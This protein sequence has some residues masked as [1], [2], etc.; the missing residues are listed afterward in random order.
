MSLP[1]KISHK[2]FLLIAVPIFFDLLFILILWYL[3]ARTDEIVNAQLSARQI[4][5]EVEGSISSTMQSSVSMTSYAVF[6]QAVYLHRFNQQL[7]TARSLLDKLGASVAQHPEIAP[8]Y[9]DFDKSL[10]ETLDLLSGVRESIETGERT[11]VL[12]IVKR[13]LR[14]GIDHCVDSA[15]KLVKLSNEATRQCMIEEESRR[16]IA[17]TVLFAGIGANLGLGV[18]F[19]ILFSRDITGRIAVIVDNAA[20]LVGGKTLQPQVGGADEIAHL[21]KVFHSM[22]KALEEAARKERAMIDKAVDVIC[23]LDVDYRV[24]KMNAAGEQL[25]HMPATEMVGKAIT[26]LI[27]PED[28]NT[29]KEALEKLKAKDNDTQMLELRYDAGGSEG[30]TLW[31]INWSSF[32]QAYFCVVHDITDA[33][34][35][36]SLKQDFVN[37]VSHDLRTPLNSMGAFLELLKLG[38]YGELSDK[39]HKTVQMMEGNMKRLLALVNNLLDLEKMESG[40]MQLNLEPAS[41]SAI[42]N[43]ALDL[44]RGFADSKKIILAFAPDGDIEL[45]ADAMRLGQVV[46]NLVSNAVKF[47]PANS[48]VMVRIETSAGNA[49]VSVSDRGC[50]IAPEDL[51]LVFEKFKQIKG[52]EQGGSGLGLA[53][54]KAIVEAHKGHIGVESTLGEGTTF[55]LTIPLVGGESAGS[56]TAT[57]EQAES[58]EP[59]TETKLVA[60]TKVV[61]ES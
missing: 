45:D 12:P 22:A 29:L 35:I 11:G 51:G 56:A 14:R 47:S 24:S 41:L 54:C 23:S 61:A 9:Q 34:N 2:G 48:T 21:D 46:Q 18:F 10:R 42:I 27:D 13:Q 60:D 25:W 15:S 19:C 31:S 30:W 20:R 16:K 8:A 5:I 50:G 40:K 36:E 57:E 59:A 52:K 38:A 1:L 55:W 58:V 43:G 33:K 7:E 6:R 28:R 26:E 3:Q 32:D 53:I 44:V 39:G 49:R 17:G 37:M 4:T